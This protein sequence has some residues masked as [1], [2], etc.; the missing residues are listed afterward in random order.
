MSTP[1]YFPPSESKKMQQT[2]TPINQPTKITLLF[3]LL[4]VLAGFVLGGW[5]VWKTI[6]S[7]QRDLNSAIETTGKLNITDHPVTYDMLVAGKKARAKKA[8]YFSAS[9]TDGKNYTLD[10][11][12]DDRQLLLLFIKHDCPCSETAQP[13]FN[14][15]AK[16]YSAKILFLGVID[17]DL[18]TARK[19]QE[20]NK[21]PFP[22]LSVPNESIMR[23]YEVPNGA[24]SALILKDGTIERMWPGFS[25]GILEEISS[26]LAELS[27]DKNT[28]SWKEA[29]KD[30]W[31][32]CEYEWTFPEDET[33]A[34]K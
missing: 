3:L 27:E 7:K 21:V 30:M 29:P 18:T 33:A 12:L 20:K 8:P 17:A 28:L 19:W 31:S 22:I 13:F 24:F 1:A 10:A 25:R 2:P 4:L 6:L 11:I 34:P 15:L 32:A 16:A 14:T 9:A 23:E 5:T 26:R